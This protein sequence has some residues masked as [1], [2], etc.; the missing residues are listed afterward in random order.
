[1]T[2]NVPDSYAGIIIFFFFALMILIV[3]KI[4]IKKPLL[5]IEE[6]RDA[7][8]GYKITNITIKV[9]WL[10]FGVSGINYFNKNGYLA[11]LISDL[12][13][14]D[15]ICYLIFSKNT[16]FSNKDDISKVLSLASSSSTIY[17]APPREEGRT[18]ISGTEIYCLMI[19]DIEN[20]Q[21][22]FRLLYDS[23][24]VSYFI[25]DTESN[26]D[27]I[28]S[29]I[30]NFTNLE[31]NEND[32]VSLSSDVI[33]LAMGCCSAEEEFKIFSNRYNYEEIKTKVLGS[34]G[35]RKSKFKVVAE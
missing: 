31:E 11:K 35:K 25:F 10:I 24:S 7:Y 12:K 17:Q 33:K 14:Q 32:I 3:V 5:I 29:R 21:E 19:K 8:D 1:M 34:M 4:L 9:D 6:E 30:N 23:Y 20:I 13:G 22:I 28:Y 15:K 27:I 16:S 2:I 18:E 26:K